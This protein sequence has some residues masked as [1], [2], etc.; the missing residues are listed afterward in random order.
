MPK[1]LE[2][3]TVAEKPCPEGL[4]TQADIRTWL[5]TWIKERDC[6]GPIEKIEVTEDGE[7]IAYGFCKKEKQ[8]AQKWRF[9]SCLLSHLAVLYLLVG[10]HDFN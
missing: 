10:N 6:S 9:A 7:W 5:N 8:C 4:L 3:E 1:K 2:W